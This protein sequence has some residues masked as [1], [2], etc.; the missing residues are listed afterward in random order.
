MLDDQLTLKRNKS[1]NGGAWRAFDGLRDRG[2]LVFNKYLTQKKKNA[3]G[4]F[5]CCT[6]LTA[7]VSGS[8][9][10]TK[11][12]SRVF[13][14]CSHLIWRARLGGTGKSRANRKRG[15][16]FLSTSFLLGEVAFQIELP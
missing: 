9:N 13:L 14:I 4:L 11:G 3:S 10:F 15:R 16:G 12:I 1:F 6:A 8:L 5:M 7:G 2:R